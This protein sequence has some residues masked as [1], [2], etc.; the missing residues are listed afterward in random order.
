MNP[1]VRNILAVIAGIIAGGLANTILITVGPHV[2]PPP[3]GMDVNNVE[4]IRV[5]AH[6][7]QP[8]HF[9]FPFLAHA[10]NAFVGGLVAYVVAASRRAVFAWAMGVLSLCGGIAAAIMIPAPKWF[11]V[12]DLVVAY[13]PMAWLAIKLGEKLTAKPAAH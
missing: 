12:L 10:M 3:A 8:Q 13:L 7:L 2:F 6:E 5:H 1:I 11:L 4:S 9:V